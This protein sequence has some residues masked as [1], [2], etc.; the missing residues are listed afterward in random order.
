MSAFLQNF[1]EFLILWTLH[2]NIRRTFF[3]RV[4]RISIIIF[5]LLIVI[6]R[7]VAVLF[8]TVAVVADFNVDATAGASLSFF[9]KNHTV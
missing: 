8:I 2:R 3:A 6:Q 7:H 5:C 9:V 1:A 4:V